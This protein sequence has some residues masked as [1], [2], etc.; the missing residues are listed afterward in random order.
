[1]DSFL[2]LILV[3]FADIKQMHLTLKE[4]NILY[5]PKFGVFIQHSPIENVLIFFKHVLNSQLNSS[6]KFKLT[7]NNSTF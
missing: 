3:Q 4:S 7:T 1:M 6:R 5:S 2:V